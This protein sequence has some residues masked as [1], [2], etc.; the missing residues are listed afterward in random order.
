MKK[1]LLIAALFVSTGIISS[2]TKEKE[3]APTSV[4]KKVADTGDD[5][6]IGGG[7]LGTGDGGVER[8]PVKKP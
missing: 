4:A 8:P 2:C 6:E 3:V 7:G 5:E 1:I